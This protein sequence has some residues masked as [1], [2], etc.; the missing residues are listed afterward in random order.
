MKFFSI[1][2]LISLL[3]LTH[4]SLAVPAPAAD[5]APVAD[6]APEGLSLAEPNAL[7]K[8]LTTMC[9]VSADNTIY[10][11]CPWTYCMAIGKY[12]KGKKVAVDCYK[13][14]Q[15]VGGNK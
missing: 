13:H 4:S 11:K 3:A 14:G 5:P 6:A 12:P 8:R 15:A 10:R 2:L 7:E 1:P 9:T